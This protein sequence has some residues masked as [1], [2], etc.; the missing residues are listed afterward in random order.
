M[1]Q[2]Q[3]QQPSRAERL[4]EQG[5]QLY[6]AHRLVDALKFYDRAVNEAPTSHIYLS[7]R[8]ACLY[9]LGR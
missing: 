6:K 7:N 8:S 2:Q 1:Q 3:Q 9:E 4:K 5:N